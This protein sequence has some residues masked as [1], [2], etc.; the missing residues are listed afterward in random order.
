MGVGACALALF[1]EGGLA[2]LGLSSLRKG[3]LPAS[4]CGRV[5]TLV[6]A[7]ACVYAYVSHSC[8]F[9][10]IPGGR[11]WVRGVG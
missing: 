9:A 10:G 1:E 5:C 4:G 8:T 11:L 3:C 6:F 7:C 2:L